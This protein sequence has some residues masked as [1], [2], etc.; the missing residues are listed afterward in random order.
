MSE[1]SAFNRHNENREIRY[2]DGISMNYCATNSGS[3]EVELRFCP[4]LI[5]NCVARA[6]LVSMSLGYYVYA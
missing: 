6:E 3:S 4:W 5:L 2:R 1:K